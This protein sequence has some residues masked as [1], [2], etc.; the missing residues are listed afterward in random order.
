MCLFRIPRAAAG[1]AQAF[2]HALKPFQTVTGKLL[3]RCGTQ[4]KRTCGKKAFL[5]V[6]RVKRQGTGGVITGVVHGAEPDGEFI[7]IIFKERK[8]HFTCAHPCV[9]FF[10]AQRHI[11][12]QTA[13]E[14]GRGKDAQAVRCKLYRQRC[15][16]G[17]R[18]AGS[19]QQHH[20]HPGRFGCLPDRFKL[21]LP[22]TAARHGIDH[23][24]LR[25]RKKARCNCCVERI[26]VFGCAVKIIHAF[27]G[28]ARLAYAAGG[29]VLRRLQKQAGG[30]CYS[31]PNGKGNASWRRKRRDG[32]G[33]HL[34]CP[35]G[36]SRRRSFVPPGISASSS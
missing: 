19:R 11:G 23:I 30:M 22:H 33:F 14:C 6:Q 26:K 4:D 27:K 5:P 3:K 15:Q 8:L 32:N 34:F 2:H 25:C 1:C 9:K 29:R 17:F 7:R 18:I 36:Y 21:G 12:V 10:N 13:G 28:D 31:I 35:F 16:R 20:L 24:L